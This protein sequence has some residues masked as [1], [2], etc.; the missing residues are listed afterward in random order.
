MCEAIVIALVSRSWA[1]VN[2]PNHVQVVVI[3]VDNFDFFWFV[4]CVWDWPTYTSLL[5]KVDDALVVGMVELSR[6]NEWI[7]SWGIDVVSDLFL[8]D[9]NVVTLCLFEEWHPA[10]NWSSFLERSHDFVIARCVESLNRT[11]GC[12]WTKNRYTVIILVHVI[13][14]FRFV[15][16]IRAHR[17]RNCERPEIRSLA[18]DATGAA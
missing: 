13:L 11:A 7:D 15:L 12:D 2:I 8:D 5:I 17:N 6:A 14:V 16:E 4:E 1:R 3:D 18:H 9:A 10:A